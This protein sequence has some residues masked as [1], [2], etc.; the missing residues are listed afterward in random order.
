MPFDVVFEDC[1]KQ[2]LSL[3]QHAYSIMQSDMAAF[4]VDK[5]SAFL[6]QLFANYREEAEASISLRVIQKQRELGSLLDKIETNSRQ[7]AIEILLQQ[8]KQRLQDKV[9]NP[10]KEVSFKFRINKQNSAYLTEDSSCMEQEYYDRV[11][12]YIRALVE[13]YASKP[14]LQRERIWMQQL[15][16]DIEAAIKGQQ[17]L[18][19]QLDTGQQY[20]VK[21]F[22]VTTD[23][24]SMYHY[25]VGLA[26]PADATTETY[27]CFSHRISTITKLKVTRAR[28]F[29]SEAQAKHL[30]EELL[31][32]GAPFMDASVLLVEVRFT[33]EG[34]RKFRR[35]L[36]MRPDVSIQKG[37]GV[38]SFYC[39]LRQAEY[40]FFKFGADVQILAPVSLAMQFCDMY[41]KAALAY[42]KTEKEGQHN[43]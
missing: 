2:H 24:L 28:S 20:R 26:V 6:N 12:A 31:R 34:E 16:D 13:E 37:D 19:V 39:T 18:Q 8:Y 3:S 36:H 9:K 10:V 23:R 7:Q 14:Y 35:I 1:N 17:L 27:A 4:R 33:S 22:R 38:Y 15:F 11:G 42:K 21:P 32:R 41:E 25:I 40:Y 43:E 5:K 30:S 29:I